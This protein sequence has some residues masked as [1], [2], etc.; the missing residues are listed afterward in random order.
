MRS[1]FKEGYTEDKMR[2]YGNIVKLIWAAPAAHC[3]YGERGVVK[4]DRSNLKCGLRNPCLYEECDGMKEEAFEQMLDDLTEKEEDY[5][6][7]NSG[8]YNRKHRELL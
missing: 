3:L 6:Q 4:A 7:V 5:L 2:D 1:A 8:E